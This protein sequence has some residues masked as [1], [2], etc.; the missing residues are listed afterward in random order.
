[1]TAK[2]ATAQYDVANLAAARLIAADPLRYPGL[3]AKW[4]RT[5]LERSAAPPA[6]VEAG[7]LFR[8]EAA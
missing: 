8:Q 1:M 5:V 4:A 6:D 7:P 2:R 3:A